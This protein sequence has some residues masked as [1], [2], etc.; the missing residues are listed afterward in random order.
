V[1]DTLRS[2]GA[3][4]ETIEDVG[5][6]FGLASVEILA[7]TSAEPGMYLITGTEFLDSQQNSVNFTIDF[8]TVPIRIDL[9]PSLQIPRTFHTAVSIDQGLYLFTGGYQGT[10]GTA[11]NSSEIYLESANRFFVIDD[12]V[13]TRSRFLHTATKLPSQRILVLGGFFSSGEAIEGAQ[14]FTWGLDP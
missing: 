11:L 9:L 7:P 1:G 8:S 12:R 2:L 6:A 14:Y 5:P 3:V 10:L 13:P 4:G